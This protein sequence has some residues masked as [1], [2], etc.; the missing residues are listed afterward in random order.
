MVLVVG[1]LVGG[2]GYGDAS[3]SASEVRMA[4]GGGMLDVR[5]V[6]VDQVIEL[7]ETTLSM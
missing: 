6:G 4:G 5:V 7:A 1:V 2:A 3:G